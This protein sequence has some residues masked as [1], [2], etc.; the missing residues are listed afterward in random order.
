MELVTRVANWHGAAYDHLLIAAEQMA[1]KV[2]IIWFSSNYL[3][4]V[5]NIIG[6]NSCT[7]VKCR[8]EILVDAA[9]SSSRA[10]VHLP[11]A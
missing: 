2:E 5:G 1:V 11:K 8:S 4:P 9:S 7:F 10:K 3:H 6:Q